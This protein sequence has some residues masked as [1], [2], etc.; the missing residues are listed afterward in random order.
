MEIKV[1]KWGGRN[2]FTIWRDGKQYR[3]LQ[4]RE[5]GITATLSEPTVSDAGNPTTRKIA[6]INLETGKIV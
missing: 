1:T 4:F 3:Y 5:D 6:V 2:S